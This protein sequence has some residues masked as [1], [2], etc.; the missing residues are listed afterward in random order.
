VTFALVKERKASTVK[1][2]KGWDFRKGK[3]YVITNKVIPVDQ[4]SINKIL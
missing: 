4:G 2:A 1:I 3:Q